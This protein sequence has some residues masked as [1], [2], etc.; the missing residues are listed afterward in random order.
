MRRRKRR[1]IVRAKVKEREN[2]GKT[3]LEKLVPGLYT[4]KGVCGRIARTGTCVESQGRERESQPKSK[5]PSGGQKVLLHS[6]ISTFVNSE[7]LIS[8]SSTLPISRIA[9]FSLYEQGHSFQ[10]Q[11]QDQ[12]CRKEIDPRHF[13]SPVFDPGSVSDKQIILEVLQPFSPLES[14]FFL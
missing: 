12:F 13:D 5:F 14:S 7:T 4:S 10:N 9:V 11:A 2:F 3:R 6:T 8:F 1:C